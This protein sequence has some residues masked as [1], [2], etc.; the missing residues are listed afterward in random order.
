MVS[1]KLSEPCKCQG[2]CQLV[3]LGCFR[4]SVSQGRER[5][6]Y[7]PLVMV[8]VPEVFTQVSEACFYRTWV[9]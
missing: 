6:S 2:A 5:L 3:G 1:D 9:Q 8:T 4:N 7:S